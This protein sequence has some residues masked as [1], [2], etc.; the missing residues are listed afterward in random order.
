MQ[1]K[2]T[3]NP[4]PTSSRASSFF[5]ENILGNGRNEHG[6]VPNSGRGIHGAEVVLTGGVPSAHHAD[7]GA[8]AP[9]GSGSTAR[10]SPIQLS[11]GGTDLNFRALETPQSE[12][13]SENR[14]SLNKVCASLS[15]ADTLRRR[16]LL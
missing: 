7:W 9:D 2:L 12:Y 5:I 11:R 8:A 16:S 14:S 3:D 1:E 13:R 10:E 15:G 6:S 4:A